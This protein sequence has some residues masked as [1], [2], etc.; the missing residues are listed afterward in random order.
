MKILLV[1]IFACVTAFFGKNIIADQSTEPVLE[2]EIYSNE[3]FGYEI[4]NSLKFKVDD[5]IPELVVLEKQGTSIRINS[6]C[7]DFGVEGLQ[8]TTNIISLNGLPAL[9]EDFYVN[10]KLVLQKITVNDQ[11]RCFSIE[12]MGGS[13]DGWEQ[14]NLLA[15]SFRLTR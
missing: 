9:K 12:I 6:G 13:E 4:N 10:S 8:V 2:N 3:K 5:S 15:R 1:L 14:G 11:D 7:F